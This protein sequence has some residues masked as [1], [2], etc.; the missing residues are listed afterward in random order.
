MRRMSGV[1]AA[2]LR[3]PLHGR[4]LL[5]GRALGGVCVRSFSARP[6]R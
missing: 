1:D 6:T 3:L 4:V 2:A 5:H